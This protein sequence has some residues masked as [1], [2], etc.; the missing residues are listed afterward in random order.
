MGAEHILNSS[1][2]DFL[3]KLQELAKK[4]K[5]TVCFESVAGDLTGQLLSRMPYGSKCILYGCLSEQP[6]GDIEALVL[7]GRNQRLEGFILNNWIKE[8]SLWALSG[9]VGKCQKLMRNKMLQSEVARR[10]SLF[11]VETALPEYKKNMTLGKY[12]IYPQEKKPSEEE[13]KTQ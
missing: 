4:L 6:V 1:D 7:I 8:K 2:A 11:E 13:S 12:V 9:I 5:A 10:I 3:D